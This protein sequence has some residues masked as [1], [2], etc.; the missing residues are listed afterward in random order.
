MAQQPNDRVP[1]LVYPSVRHLIPGPVDD[2]LR[3][4]ID[5]L[6]YMRAQVTNLVNGS[7]QLSTGQSSQ[8][9]QQIQSAASQILQSAAAVASASPNLVGTHVNRLNAYSSPLPSRAITFF[10]TDRTAYYIVAEDLSGIVGWTLIAAVMEAALASRPTDLGIRDIGFVFLDT[11]TK[12]LSIW[13]GTAWIDIRADAVFKQGTYA[14]RPAVAAADNGLVYYSTDQDVYWQVV[15]GVW[16]YMCGEMRGTLIPDLK[17]VLVAADAGFLFYSTDYNHVY[18]WDGAA[19]GL[20][21]GEDTIGEIRFFDGAVNPGTG[22]K[23]CDGAGAIRSTPTGGT[24]GVVVPDYTTS[25]YVKASNGVSIGPNAAAGLTTNVSAGTPAGTI[26]WPVGVPT[27]AWPVN[28]PTVSWPAGVPA[29]AWPVGVPTFA[30]VALGTHQHELPF[31]GPDNVTIGWFDKTTF[32]EGTAANIVAKAP[33]LP[34]TTNYNRALDK[35]TSAGTPSGTVAWPV[36]VPTASWPAGVPTTAWP[37]NVPTASWPAG[38]PTFSGVALAG[39]DHGPNTLE[40]RNTVLKAYYR[41]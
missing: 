39:H 17:P 8:V 38:V 24:A 36:G 29:I 15:S 18:R 33:G 13:S 26:A 4:V 2:A 6:F 28:A 19:W 35:A 7:S 5:N 23:L 9:T 31:C 14:A 25:A 30:G 37:A 11:G 22:W 12:K 40:L 32:G 41:L 27:I 16:K 1:G 20:A 21:P 10:E 3:N 34:D